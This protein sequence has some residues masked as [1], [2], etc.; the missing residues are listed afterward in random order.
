MTSAQAGF[1]AAYTAGGVDGAGTDRYCLKRVSV[2]AYDGSL[3]FAWKA[4]TGQ[5]VPPVW[6]R[7]RVRGCAGGAELTAWLRRRARAGPQAK[8]RRSSGTA[9]AISG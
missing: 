9:A 7:W 1:A 2:Y 8:P 4:L 6:E 5:A 3:A